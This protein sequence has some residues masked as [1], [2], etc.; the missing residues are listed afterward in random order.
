ME[1]EIIK[2][3]EEEIEKL[4]NELN[5]TKE[6]LKKYTSPARHKNYYE[7][8]REEILEKM[9]LKPPMDKDKR[10]E[11]NRRAYLKKKEK[12]KENENI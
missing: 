4:R 3:L 8:H 6:H 12:T 11:I 1:N 7:N 9:K 2:Q 10:K 5:Q